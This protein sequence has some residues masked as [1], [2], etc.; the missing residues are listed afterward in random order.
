M[1]L[2]AVRTLAVAGILFAT[3]VTARSVQLAMRTDA[4]IFYIA[5]GAAICLLLLWL[6]SLLLRKPRAFERPVMAIA[7]AL[8]VFPAMSL[9]W[10]G[11]RDGLRLTPHER[12]ALEYLRTIDRLEMTHVGFLVVPSHAFIAM[13]MIGRSTDADAA[14]KELLRTGTRSGQVYGLIGVRRTD[15]AYFR[16]VYR[17][18]AD[19]DEEIMV[20]G[21]CI[22]SDQQLAPIVRTKGAMQLAPG[23]RLDMFSPMPKGTPVL[24][25]DIAGGAYSSI[26]LDRGPERVEKE[27]RDAEVTYDFTRTP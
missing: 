13:R 10:D 1:R 21:G 19:S 8:L 22:M 12:E 6:A 4:A 25:V 26:F 20:F 23:Q 2:A 7:I 18:Y 15:P 3:G 11:T 27:L 17:A 24:P 16:M 9:L 14:F 5:C